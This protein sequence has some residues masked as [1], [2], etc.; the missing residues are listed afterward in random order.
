MSD[1]L[2]FTQCSACAPDTAHPDAARQT[3]ACAPGAHQPV[4]PQPRAR[5][6]A[7]EPRGVTRFGSPDATR[8]M[9]AAVGTP[10][11]TSPLFLGE[12]RRVCFPASQQLQPR[13][14]AR[15]PLPPRAPRFGIGR[16]V[17]PHHVPRASVARGKPRAGRSAATPGSA[18][19]PP[20]TL[21][22]LRSAR[23]GQE[24]AGSARIVGLGR[25]RRR[26]AGQPRASPR[27]DAPRH[28]GPGA[29]AL[30][31]SRGREAQRWR[32]PRKC[33][34]P[35]LLAQRRAGGDPG[36]RAPRARNSAR[37]PG[38]PRGAPPQPRP[39]IGGRGRDPRAGRGP[40][41]RGTHCSRR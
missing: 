9:P 6:P 23:L 19:R 13:V 32:R 16:R 15:A 12:R 17:P 5:G 29:R 8:E 30:P 38:G 11:L 39:G 34:T 25:E 36:D 21:R 3:P 35:V 41:P 31:R 27:R 28:P 10:P 22:R 4:P 26:Y 37:T 7:P 1:H 24:A 33:R 18:T 14:L 40:G 2:P 20:Q